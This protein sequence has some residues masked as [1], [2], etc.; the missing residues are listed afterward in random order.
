[1][2]LYWL[3]RG[4]PIDAIALVNPDFSY[5]PVHWTAISGGLGIFNATVATSKAMNGPLLSGLVINMLGDATITSTKV[6]PVSSECKQSLTCVSYTM[7]CGPRIVT[8][9]PYNNTVDRSLST[10]ITRSG[11]AYQLDFWNAPFGIT[12]ASDDCQIYGESTNAFQLCV[13][14]YSGSQIVAG[15]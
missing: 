12:W 9:W 4:L 2:N 13:S 8:P 14:S 5:V 6:E 3:W 7:P 11:P 15:Q 10:H 1:M